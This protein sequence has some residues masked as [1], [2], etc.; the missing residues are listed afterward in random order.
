[1]RCWGQERTGRGQDQEVCRGTPAEERRLCLQL[2]LRVWADLPS[3]A[4]QGCQWG[5]QEAA[6]DRWPASQPLLSSLPC[7]ATHSLCSVHH[8]SRVQPAPSFQQCRGHPT[9]WSLSSPGE[10]GGSA[11]WPNHTPAQACPTVVCGLEHVL[12]PSQ[13]VPRGDTPASIRS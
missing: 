1:M 4:P 6:E 8:R 10:V 3:A 2:G 12:S 11:G 7:W 13:P 9:L 5:L